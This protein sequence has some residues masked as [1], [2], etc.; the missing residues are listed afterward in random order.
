M[1]AITIIVI[2][3]YGSHFLFT[4]KSFD[5]NKG[6]RLTLTDACK[7]T[8]K[9]LNVFLPALLCTAKA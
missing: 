2:K 9:I 5:K 8:L 6:L 4:L 7:T 1:M 3:I